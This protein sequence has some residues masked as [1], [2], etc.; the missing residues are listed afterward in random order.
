MDC[1]VITASQAARPMSL[2]EAFASGVPVV[3]TPVGWSKEWIRDGENG[4]LVRN[5]SEICKAIQEIYKNRESWFNKCEKIP[6]A[7]KGFT[8]ESWLEDNIDMA[9]RLVKEYYA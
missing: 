3:S 4:Y 1:I 5:V 8:L 2:F 7:L 6:E 9:V